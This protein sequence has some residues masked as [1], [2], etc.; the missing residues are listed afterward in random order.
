MYDM[1]C[2]IQVPWCDDKLWF[3]GWPD[4]VYGGYIC[5]NRKKF[6]FNMCSGDVF[7]G[8]CVVMYGMWDEQVV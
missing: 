6:M 1:Y 5:S 8:W 3:N 2:G 7:W 4:P